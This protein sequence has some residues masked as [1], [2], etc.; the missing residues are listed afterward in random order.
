MGS[1]ESLICHSAFIS[2]SSFFENV[3]GKSKTRKQSLLKNFKVKKV[4]FW[5]SQM[6]ITTD[7]SSTLVLP[8]YKAPLY[9]KERWQCS[10]K[11]Q[12]AIGGCPSGMY[13]LLD[14]LRLLSSL[15]SSVTFGLQTLSIFTAFLSTHVGFSWNH[16][17]L[18]FETRVS[19]ILHLFLSVFI[20]K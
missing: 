9:F 6:M 15:K 18:F 12:I 16:N 4:I 17:N 3:L 13:S 10:F 8:F 11:L 14:S 5:C 19:P 20:L 7:N 2:T 1:I